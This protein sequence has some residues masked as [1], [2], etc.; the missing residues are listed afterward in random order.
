MAN[1]RILLLEDHAETRQAT[2]LI[3]SEAGYYIQSAS[4]GKQ[5]IEFARLD[6]FDLLL[7]D[8]FLP[9]G[10]GVDV[11]TS[12][13]AF[14][15]EIAGIVITIQ[16][17][18]ELTMEAM[19]AGFVG[20]LVKPVVPEQLFAAIVG[21]LEQEK[22]RQENARLRA[23]V[24]LYELSRAFM[25]TLELGDLLHQVVTTIQ[26]ETRAESVSLMLLEDDHK[27]LR[28]AASAG[29]PKQVIE[30]QTT[31]L[32]NGIAGRVAQRGEPLIISDHPLL[33]PEI[34]QSMNKPEIVS[35][36]SLPLRSR[37]QVIGVLN[38]SRMRGNEPFT[39]GDL[40]LVTVFASQAAI[41][42]DNA[43][44]FNQLKQLSEI[45]QRLTRTASL[46]A[47]CEIIVQA[48]TDLVHARGAAL[49]LTDGALARAPR[50]FGIEPSQ[51]PAIAPRMVEEFQMKDELGWLTMPLR[52]GERALGAL[53]ISLPSADPLNEERLELLRT[54]AH[55][56]GAVIESHQLRERERFAFREVDLA[57]RSDLGLR[58]LLERLLNEIVNACD[59]DGGAFFSWDTE[60]ST[61]ETWVTQGPGAEITW[62]R[63]I[64]DKGNAGT[65]LDESEKWDV[66]GAPMRIGQRT[67]GAIVLARTSSTRPFHAEHID[68]ISTFASAAALA[69]RNAQL[70][71][72]S[73]EAA[74]AEERT[75]IAREIHDGLAQD[76]SYLVLKIGAAQKLATQ[77]KEKELLKELRDVSDQLRRDARDVRRIIYALRPLD[78]ETLGF[79]P[80]LKQFTRE[81]GQANEIDLQLK[82]TGETVRLSPKLETALFRLTQETLNNI[83]KHAQ[84]KHVWV[85]LDLGDPHHATLQV[86]DDGT[87]FELESALQAARARGSVGLVQMRE[88]AERAGGTF[89]IE[90]ATGQGTTVRAQLPIRES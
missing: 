73:E 81:F 45:S 11:F 74:I 64:I 38:V 89:T 78:I 13:R 47:A 65:L 55:G 85:E 50:I 52:S 16:S 3:L 30:N 12:I 53:S 35:A 15:P 51:V 4:T 86:R 40:E 9:D 19:R 29:L 58:D 20:F 79:L 76:L 60:A 28:I 42:I 10:S 48:P 31:I 22:L 25:G 44:L 8:V 49:W 87:G 75:R 43:R 84:A 17:T 14:R 54:L 39:P 71:A 88:R 67:Q 5:A 59:A 2:A 34:R 32:G 26:K 82:V 1:E 36:L 41:A 83:R 90:T 7:A 33:D 27:E 80:A 77:G 23:L 56:A 6:H 62:A 66:I 70:Y 63:Q 61:L 72:R 18:W 24:P 46:A 37:G 68:L 69:V 57:V 21:A